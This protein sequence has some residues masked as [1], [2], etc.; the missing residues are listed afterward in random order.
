MKVRTDRPG[1]REECSSSGSVLVH[2]PDTP[3]LRADRLLCLKSQRSFCLTKQTLRFHASHFCADHTLASTRVVP[4]RIRPPAGRL[5]ARPALA[6]HTPSGFA[7][8]ASRHPHASCPA[9][10]LSPSQLLT[11]GYGA[12]NALTASAAPV[13]AIPSPSP[14]Q[15][16]GT[17][18]PPARAAS[19]FGASGSA[20]SVSRPFSPA[21]CL[22]AKSTS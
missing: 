10:R 8:G 9:C 6:C 13:L 11:L 21:R 3:G 1:N 7:A 22:P 16:Y 19:A 4:G 20:A 15:E 5:L 14:T 2:I 17:H 12:G 18:C